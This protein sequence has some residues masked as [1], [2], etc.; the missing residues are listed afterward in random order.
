VRAFLD[1]LSVPFRITLTERDLRMMKVQ[2]TMSDT[3]RNEKGA[4]ALCVIRRSL[5]TMRTHD[6]SLLAAMA[7][8]FDG[9]PFPRAW[10]PGT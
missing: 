3:F 8:V 4:T 2:H 1:D 10:E 5:S 7:A 9:S 6:R